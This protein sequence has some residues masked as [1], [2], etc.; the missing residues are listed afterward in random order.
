MASFTGQIFLW[1]CLARQDL[2]SLRDNTVKGRW[3]QIAPSENSQLPSGRDKEA[4][5]HCAFVQSQ[6]RAAG[7]GLFCDAR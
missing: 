6:V 4:C 1:E 2:D 7:V 3:S 5:L